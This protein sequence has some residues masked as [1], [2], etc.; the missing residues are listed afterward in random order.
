MV[1]WKKCE[2]RLLQRGVPTQVCRYLFSFQA[3]HLQNEFIQQRQRVIWFILFHSI[4]SVL[5]RLYCIINFPFCLCDVQYETQ[6]F[7]LMSQQFSVNLPLRADTGFSDVSW[8]L[9]GDSGAS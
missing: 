2:V 7:L 8:E 3:K 1:N 5:G 4:P 6:V 9:G